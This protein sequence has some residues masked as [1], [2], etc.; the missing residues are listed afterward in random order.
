MA[1]ISQHILPAGIEGA[2]I[3]EPLPFELC[4]IDVADFGMRN[5]GA[6]AKRAWM[7]SAR[8]H[9]WLA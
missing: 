4:P 7:G 9:R 5:K 8:C 6:A 3:G 2:F 1:K